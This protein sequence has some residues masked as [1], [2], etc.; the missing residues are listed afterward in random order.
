M[1]DLGGPEFRTQG[2]VP[3]DRGASWFT[4]WMQENEIPGQATNIHIQPC[5]AAIRDFSVEYGPA[6]IFARLP[7]ALMRC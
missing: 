1:N 5:I 6:T 4:G 2:Q 7:S 3:I